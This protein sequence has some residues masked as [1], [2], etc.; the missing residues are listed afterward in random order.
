M[1]NIFKFFILFSFVFSPFVSHA[2]IRTT[3]QSRGIQSLTGSD[4]PKEKALQTERRGEDEIMRR[5]NSLRFVIDRLENSSRMPIELRSKLINVAREQLSDLIQLQKQSD[6]S[7]E[8]PEFQ[9]YAK[10]ISGTYRSYSITSSVALFE[11]ALSR[12]GAVTHDIEAL[13]NKL[14]LRIA[15]ISNNSDLL[16][17]LDD[18]NSEIKDANKNLEMAKAFSNDLP[19]PVDEKSFL[20][21]R[22]KLKKA[23][24]ALRAVY[25]SIS[26]AKQDASVIAESLKK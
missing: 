1:K 18:L 11:V 9:N 20:T 12:A 23:H 7:I 26:I 21:A 19:V 24:E 6:T 14:G 5:I 13:S 3:S 10:N 22:G 25:S 16:S 2:Q 15:E 4:L 17:A 8:T